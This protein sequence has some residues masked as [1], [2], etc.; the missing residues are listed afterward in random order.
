MPGTS[1]RERADR[2]SAECL[3]AFAKEISD[4][5]HYQQVSKHLDV[6]LAN[7]QKA[8]QSFEAGEREVTVADN[9]G[10]YLESFAEALL[11]MVAESQRDSLRLQATRSVRCR[12]IDPVMR[13]IA[14]AELTLRK[15]RVNCLTAASRMIPWRARS[16]KWAQMIDVART[17]YRVATDAWRQFRDTQ[18][19]T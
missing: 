19:E 6:F 11:F 16:T 1:R 10:D 8:R 12:Q 2:R 4:F 5:P 13:P 9:F 3:I 17:E 18:A 7:L 15:L 14:E